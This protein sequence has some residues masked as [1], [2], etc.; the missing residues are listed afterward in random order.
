[1]GGKRGLNST[2]ADVLV[3]NIV[4]KIVETGRERCGDIF[5]CSPACCYARVD[6]TYKLI[7]FPIRMPHWKRLFLCAENTQKK[8]FLSTVYIKE[9][10]LFLPWKMY[11]S[12]VQWRGFGKSR[13]VTLGGSNDSG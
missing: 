12:I 1:M 10:R 6:Q 13:V 4:S 7:P 8:V 2:G 3:W 9:H 5:C 11:I